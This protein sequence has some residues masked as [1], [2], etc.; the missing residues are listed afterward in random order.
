MGKICENF[1][2][3][4]GERKVGFVISRR[5]GNA[6]ERNRVKRLM[7][8]VYRK[9]KYEIENYHIIISGRRSMDS[10]GYAE[11]EKELCRF[12]REVMRP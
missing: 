4:A 5:F 7:R 11:L 8:E 6:V 10:A 3:P 9:H 1:F 2:L 12:I